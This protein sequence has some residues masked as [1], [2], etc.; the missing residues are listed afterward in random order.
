MFCLDNE[1]F[2]FLCAR[3]N[4]IDF[5]P[6]DFE[7]FSLSWDKSAAETQRM[8]SYI[9]NR[10]PHNV[11]ETMSI[12]EARNTILTLARPMAK[13]SDNIATNIRVAKEQKKFT[14]LLDD[15]KIKLEKNRLVEQI[16]I[17]TVPIN[18]PKTVCTNARCIETRGI[19]GTNEQMVIYKT[20]CHDH[21]YL[22]GVNIDTVGAPQL[23]ECAAMGGTTSCNRCG[24]IWQNH[25][26][27]TY[28]FEESKITVPDLLIEKMI[29]DN[30]ETRLVK[31]QMIT[32]LQ[33]KIDKYKL[34]QD[35]ILTISSQFG[36]LLKT[37]AI[38]PY[39][40][41]FESHVRHELRLASAE[42]FISADSAKKKEDLE[43]LLNEYLEKKRMLDEAMVNHITGITVD[44]VG[45][46]KD[47]LMSLPLS[48][49]SFKNCFEVAANSHSQLHEFVEKP[50]NI[51]KRNNRS[52]KNRVRCLIDPWKWRDYFYRY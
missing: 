23:K 10:T 36:S 35:Q 7:N 18:Y 46:L 37:N 21:C 16:Q 47:Q 15:E 49:E 13:I 41:A 4:N 20:I 52:F 32:N 27:I 22:S 43:F 19:P 1:A 50:H 40:D 51:K 28:N 14:I 48:G 9:K 33:E 25:M 12:N 11:N 39:N 34:E 45:K 29:K 17:R 6:E 30:A 26:H 5:K 38:I 42:E 2:R 31:E 8:L 44:D 24:C 3:R